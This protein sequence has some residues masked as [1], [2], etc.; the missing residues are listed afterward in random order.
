MSHLIVLHSTSCDELGLSLDLVQG[1][2]LS[3]I[4]R[5]RRVLAYHVE[6]DTRL[7]Q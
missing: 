2:V 7:R 1:H 5:R 6:E 4:V 3:L